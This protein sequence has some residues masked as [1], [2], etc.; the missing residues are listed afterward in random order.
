MQVL[1][2]SYTSWRGGYL[3]ILNNNELII[4]NKE[5]FGEIRCI[6]IE[7][8]FY[9]AGKDIA[10][11]LGYSNPTKAII[12]HCN[13]IINYNL[14]TNRGKQNTNIICNDDIILL[15]QKSQI[16][17]VKYR[18]K[19]INWLIKEKIIQDKIVLKIKDEIE[20]LDML[21]KVLKPFKYTCIRQYLVCNSKYK[22]DLYIKELNIAIEYDERNHNGYTYKQHKGRQLKIEKELGCK[23][24]RVND[25]ND[26]FYNVGLVMKQ[27]IA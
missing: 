13:N 17:S 9:V 22:I 11:I 19:I 15:I 18:Q 12:Q 27:L 6:K 4:F 21:E 24:I 16:K 20:F 5:E 1:W 14:N 25:S 3:K 8:K 2:C 26:N 23:F 7:N 10:K